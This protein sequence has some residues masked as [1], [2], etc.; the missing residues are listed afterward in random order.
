MLLNKHI[1]KYIQ[2]DNSKKREKPCSIGYPLSCEQIRIPAGIVARR[3]R[4]SYD[5]VGINY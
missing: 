1:K 3:I 5:T 2:S 4:R